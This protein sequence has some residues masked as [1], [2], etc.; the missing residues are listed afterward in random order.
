MKQLISELRKRGVTRVAGLYIAVVWLLL[1]LSEILFPAFDIPDSALRI[2][3]YVGIAGFPVAMVI[4]WFY[5][6]TDQGIQREEDIQ[7]TGARRVGTGRTL[8]VATLV[9]LLAALGTSVYLNFQQAGE[10]P[11]VV[12]DNISVLIA[13]MDNQTGDPIFDGSLEQA[14]AIGIEGASFITSFARAQALTIA[15]Q[16]SPGASLDEARARLV[17]VREGI[18]LVL[19]GAITPDSG[20]FELALRAVDPQTGE[21][22]AEADASAD[23]KAEVLQAVGTLA[24]QIR[25]ALGDATLDDEG[26]TGNE[27]FSA[28]SLDAMQYYTQAQGLAQVGQDQ[29]AAALYEKAIAE[30]PNFGRA[31]SGWALSAYNLG[32][33]D[34]ATELWEKTLALLDGMTEREQY[35]TLGVYYTVVSRNYKKAIENY[36]L[37]VENYP[38]DA[39]GHNNLAVA[40]FLTRDFDNAAREGELVLNL[41][42]G[43]PTFRS[44]SALYAMYAGDFAKARELSQQLLDVDAGYYKARLPLAMAELVEGNIE[45]ARTAYQEMSTAGDR[46]ASLAGTGL[47]DIALYQGRYGEAIELLQAP[48]AADEEQG[49][50]FGLVKKLLMLG[51]AHLWRGEKEQALAA[52]ERALA[53]SG[54][55]SDR[56]A[57]A[58]IYLELGEIEPARALQQALAGDLASEARAAAALLEGGIQLAAGNIVPAVDALQDSLSRDDSW[59]TRLVLGRAYLLGGYH[60]EALSEFELCQSRIG[61]VTALYLDDSPSFHY[62]APLKYWLGRTKQELG[63]TR[64]AAGDLQAYLDSQQAAELDDGTIADAQAR[65]AALPA[66]G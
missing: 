55:R 66:Q 3:L 54:S 60:A 35:R 21:M 31:Y 56:L 30:D 52:V 51:E 32:Q 26:L 9:I 39:I 34:K 42:P 63:M 37:L 62:S 8:Y 29:Q 40:Y 17:A 23:T 5:E 2:V 36:E 27:T 50:N 10:A 6:I 41:Y 18:V 19:A 15:E 53:L 45:A 16:I 64:E 61:E 48:I 57:A 13:D 24:A 20:G 25:E 28:A 44:N 22:I 65:L 43:N 47:A 11:E 14:L 7:Q 46:A 12:P 1:Q 49:N 59:L 4:A 58:R 33:A 38:A